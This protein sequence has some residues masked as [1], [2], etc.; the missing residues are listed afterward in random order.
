MTWG[1]D[2][3]AP[4]VEPKVEVSF[5]K[6]TDVQQ[7]KGLKVGIYGNCN[8]GKTYFGFTS[9]KPIYFVD[10]EMGAGSV[11]LQFDS[12]NLFVKE[13]C[14]HKKDESEVLEKDDVK[15]F[16]MINQLIKSV[17]DNK[18]GTIVI[19][20]GTDLWSFCQ[21]YC[22]VKHFKIKP[23]QRLK[24]QFDWGYINNMYQN[25]IYRLL[26]SSLNVVI[27]ARSREEYIGSSPSGIFL[28]H[29]QKSTDYYLDVV[30]QNQ[31]EK[32]KTG[33]VFKSEIIKCRPN[34]KLVGKVFENLTFDKLKEVIE[35]DR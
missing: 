22:K 35:N 20:S 2:R 1:G 25:L 23:D 3:P 34:G 8:T 7:K 32:T 18:E 14:L 4:A 27:T 21:S 29:W 9:P 10:T 31:K 30:I 5:D 13:V 33:V 19:D 15:N 6:I 12:E 26:K 11:G 17:A 24:F 16:E 28:A